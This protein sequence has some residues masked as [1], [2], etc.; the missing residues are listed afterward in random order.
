MIE[1]VLCKRKKKIKQQ[2]RWRQI[3]TK[4]KTFNWLPKVIAAIS[5]FT[6][7]CY[8][9]SFSCTRQFVCTADNM[10]EIWQKWKNNQK[11]IAIRERKMWFFFRVLAIFFCFAWVWICRQY[12][13]ARITHKH[14]QNR[15]E[16]RLPRYQRYQDTHEHRKTVCIQTNCIFH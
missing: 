14:R 9:E 5:Y 4:R 8:I 6:L 13:P 2:Q 10:S 1:N 16:K 12:T 3:K 7:V 15:S 11:Q